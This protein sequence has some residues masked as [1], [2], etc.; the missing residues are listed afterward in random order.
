MLTIALLASLFFKVVSVCFTLSVVRAFLF[1]KV[2]VVRAFLFTGA[3]KDLS[4]RGLCPPAYFTLSAPTPPHL[5]HSHFV[6]PTLLVFCDQLI[7]CNSNLKLFLAQER[8]VEG[9]NDAPSNNRPVLQD[10]VNS[11]T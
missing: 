3:A 1:I 4:C 8:E 7:A 10:L 11:N 2:S 6:S 5:N 9:A